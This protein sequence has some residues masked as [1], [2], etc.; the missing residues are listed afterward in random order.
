MSLPRPYRGDGYDSTN[1]SHAGLALLTRKIFWISLIAEGSLQ[2]ASGVLLRNVSAV[3]HENEH[4]GKSLRELS[5]QF[6]PLGVCLSTPGLILLVYSLTSGN[7]AGWNTGGVI[8]PLILAICLL[9]AFILVEL[10]V[11]S[12]PLVPR[13]LWSD[14]NKSIGCAIAALTYGVW[15]GSNYLLT[16]ELQG[17]L[18]PFGQSDIS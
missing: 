12:H 17:M 5:R 6:D 8:A 11:S 14:R 15:Q 10:R 13:Y 16:L 4:R 9:S 3:N 2:I 1:S 7:Q 18:A